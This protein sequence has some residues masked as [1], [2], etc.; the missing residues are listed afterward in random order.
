MRTALA[1]I[2]AGTT[3]YDVYVRKILE[4]PLERIGS[5]ETQGPFVASS[6]GDEKL[7][8]QHMRHRHVS[9]HVSVSMAPAQ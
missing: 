6:Y 1:E 9:S 3:L 5:L 7:F 4:D 2:P 8:F